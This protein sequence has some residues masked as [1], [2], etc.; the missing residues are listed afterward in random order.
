[1]DLTQCLPKREIT[2]TGSSNFDRATPAKDLHKTCKKS[3]MDKCLR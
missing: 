2:Q 3:K 1:M